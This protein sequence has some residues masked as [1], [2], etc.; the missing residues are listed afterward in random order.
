MITS[1]RENEPSEA[2][3]IVTFIGECLCLISYAD[4]PVEKGCAPLPSKIRV[5]PPFEGRTDEEKAVSEEQIVAVLREYEA[6]AK[7]ADLARKHGVSE[8]TL[9]KWKAKYG[10]MDVSDAKR[11][12]ALGPPS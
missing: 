7:A 11:L 12:K 1:I 9:Y 4:C 5:W 6:G 8:A 10:G 3:D 2:F